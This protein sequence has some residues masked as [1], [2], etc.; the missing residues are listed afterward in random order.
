VPIQA[1]SS[2]A[3]FL[4][5]VTL[6]FLVAGVASA[7]AFGFYTWQREEQE[8][9]SNLTVLCGFLA[10]ASEAFFGNLGNGLVP[11]AQLLDKEGVLE[12]PEAARAHLQEFQDRYPE[13]KSMAVFLPDGEMLINTAVKPQ[14]PLPD[15]RKDPP[16]IRQLLQDMDDPRRYVI[17]RPEFGKALQRWRFSVR[18]VLRDAQ[19]RP[20]FMLQAAIPL[21]KD[22]TFLHQLPVPPSSFI[23]L[24]RS[25]G[26]QQAR[27]PVADTHEIY[28]RISDGPAASMIRKEP[29]IQAGYFRG[30][31][32][33]TGSRGERIGAFA[34]LPRGDMYAYVSAPV[35]YLWDRWWRHNAPVFLMFAAFLALFSF[36]AYRVAL[37]ERQHSQE[38]IGQARRDALTGLPNRAAAEEMMQ[39]CIRM[40][41]TLSRQFSVLFVD[42]D[43]FKDINDSLGHSVGDQLLVAV[44]KVIKD[45]LRDEGMLSRLGG[46]EFLA[47]LPM[48]GVESAVSVTERLIDAFRAP[49]RV[50]DHLLQV[51][52]SIGIAQFPEHGNDIG[53][54]L[55]HADTAMYEAKRQGGNAFSVYMDQLGE[56]VRQR[57]EVERQLREAIHNDSFRMV[58]QPVVD[59]RNGR[60]V[61]AEALV[62]WVRADG[63]VLMPSH[64]IGVAEESGLIHE[65]GEWVL[66]DTLAQS[67]C[68][69]D[70]GH[71]LW[72]AINISPRQF[73]DPNLTTKIAAAL[74]ES[75]VQ[76]QRVELEITETVAML[77]PETSMRVLGNLKA[78]GLRIAIDD[79]GTG[80]SSLG[81]LKRIPADKVKIDK[82]FIDGIDREADGTAIVHT[83]LALARAMEKAVVAEG[84]ETKEQFDALRNLNCCFG[85]GYW[86]GR[87]VLPGDFIRMVERGQPVVGT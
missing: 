8:V 67:K 4:R 9:R 17:G 51:T 73:Q 85:Q 25:D 59:M 76:P 75:G 78:M 46:D 66:R 7:L 49:L 45:T 13:V 84:I 70:A 60:I 5:N 28:G 29:N 82:S 37:R 79:F 19:G 43:R 68:W 36:V 53:T 31:S 56:R 12:R 55:K 62:R 38:L 6:T 48:R 3:R 69:S 52:P 16:Y 57:V 65:L 40:S 77:N 54:L 64:F 63:T 41:N 18:H 33:W 15:F 42:I 35:S 72:V 39:F 32:Y 20:R 27:W 80:Y 23:G 22:G 2:F 74:R 11:L 87:P 26:F 30:T 61:G 21:E 44:A 10:S 86:I 81:Y 83:V 47:V 58:Y 1:P 50:G 24:L 14:A 34:R 71:D